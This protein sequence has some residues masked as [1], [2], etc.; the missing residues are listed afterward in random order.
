[1]HHVRFVDPAGDVRRGEW[2]DPD[3]DEIAAHPA[4]GA[5]IS[6]DEETY[7][8]NEVEVLPPV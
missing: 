3:G 8:A 6:L 2:T 4:H 1:M 7:S 5:R